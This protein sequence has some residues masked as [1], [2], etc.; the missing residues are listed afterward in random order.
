MHLLDQI[1][2][3]IVKGFNPAEINPEE[4]LLD[5]FKHVRIDFVIENSSQIYVSSSF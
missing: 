3:R 5:T 1:S 2:D 4:T